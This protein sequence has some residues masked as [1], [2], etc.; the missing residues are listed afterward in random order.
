MNAVS[1]YNL[2][3]ILVD[4]N[5][6]TYYYIFSH[7]KVAKSQGCELASI[8]NSDEQFQALSSAALAWE[9]QPPSTS[10]GVNAT[11]IGGKR[12]KAEGGG[13]MTDGF[14]DQSPWRWSDGTPWEYTNW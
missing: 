5:K 3:F 14:V 10:R 7:Y 11:W 2:Y 12:I 4:L 9:L 1:M 8:A 13:R 6:K